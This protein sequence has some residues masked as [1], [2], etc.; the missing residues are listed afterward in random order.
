[1]KVK[2]LKDVRRKALTKIEFSTELVHE[3]IGNRQLEKI[4]HHTDS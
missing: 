3:A 2:M 4:S 1:M